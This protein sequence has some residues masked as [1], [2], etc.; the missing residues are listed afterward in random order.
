MLL[1]FSCLGSLSYSLQSKRQMG[2]F[3]ER[4]QRN[5]IFLRSTSG[6]NGEKLNLRLRVFPTQY[7]VWIVLIICVLSALS[8]HSNINELVRTFSM[9]LKPHNDRL[10]CRVI[11]YQLHILVFHGSWAMY[12]SDNEPRFM[13]MVSGGLHLALHGPFGTT[14]VS[15]LHFLKTF[16]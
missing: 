6:V 14:A 16:V 1:H 5:T 8:A 15:K 3:P 12:P 2:K 13:I 7:G 10:S 11:L 4:F 9:L